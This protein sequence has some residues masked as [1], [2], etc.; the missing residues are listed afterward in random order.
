MKALNLLV[1][2]LLA[3]GLSVTAFAADE[4][5][6]QQAREA[7]DKHDLRGAIIHLKNLLQQQPENAEARYLLGSTYLQG[8]DAASAEKELRRA[9]QLGLAEARLNELL[10]DSLLL[11]RK[12]DEVKQFI[13]DNPAGDNK[14]LMASYKA[15]DGL[16][17]FAN[18][19]TEQAKQFFDEA[20]ALD[21]NNLRARLGLVSYQ[22]NKGDNEGALKLLDAYLVEN[23]QKEKVLQMRADLH[24]KLGQLEMATADYEK[25]LSLSPHSTEALLGMA[26]I[27]ATERQPEEVLKLLDKLPRVIQETP[28]PQYLY[29]LSAFMQQNNDKAQQYLL[30]VLKRVPGHVQSH[31]LLGVIKY[32]SAEWNQAEEH[33]SQVIKQINNAGVAKLLA[34]TYIKLNQPDKA[35]GLLEPFAQATSD[36]SQLMSLLGSAYMQK[37]DNSSAQQWFSRAVE[38]SPEQAGVRTQLALGMLGQGDV[39]AAIST[40]EDAVDL[41]Q[42]LIQTDVLLVM[43]H[44][45]RGD[46]A[47]AIEISQQLQKKYPDS[48]IPPNLTGLSYLADKQFKQADDSFEQALK[49]D[50]EFQV[51]QLNLA[52][53]S[54]AAG[55]QQQAIERF[56]QVLQKDDSNITALFGLAQLAAQAGDQA[57]QISYLQQLLAKHAQNLPATLALAEVY[58]SQGD[59]LKASSTL[60]AITGKPAD[61]PALLRMKGLTQL[62]QK[63]YSDAIHSF[64][65]LAEILPDNLEAQYQL[66]RAYMLADKNDLARNVFDKAAKLDAD[67]EVALLWLT[68][69]ELELREQKFDR[70]LEI[71]ST[72]AKKHAQNPLVFEFQG[73]AYRGK[74]DLQKALQAYEKAFQL[75]PNSQRV[76]LLANL[77]DQSGLADKAIAT[78]DAWVTKHPKDTLLSARLGLMQQQAGNNQAAIVAYERTL[79]RDKDNVLVLNNLAWLYHQENNPKA[80]SLAK[81]AY[82]KASKRPEIV[83]TYGWILLQQGQVKQA[84]PILQEALL[85]SPSHPEIAFHVATALKQVGRKDEAATV[86]QRIIRNTPSSPFARQAREMLSTLK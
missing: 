64:R 82:D 38:V 25:I 41:G 70:V 12:M 22:L 75:E 13:S 39:D 1:A 2:M 27:K 47:K 84:L 86:L 37:G 3:I 80:L 74:G 43:S 73:A 14:Q 8:G 53:S 79:Q 78:V 58:L 48:P 63:Q 30:N 62:A 81:Q 5:L 16:I 44:L 77:Y 55:N 60:S 29:G 35:V 23:P 83:D 6:L 51:A 28:L 32:A 85:Q 42:D 21:S 61:H 40:L 4:N 17:A 49:I 45:K 76:Q 33:F 7:A 46:T 69:A 9:H 52:R 26:F 68:F 24:R 15:I 67:H 31:L 20:D 54:I 34:A 66:G 71:T 56:K 72:L 19:E 10:L 18:G 59:F 50:P 57:Q 11:Q 65:R 36:D